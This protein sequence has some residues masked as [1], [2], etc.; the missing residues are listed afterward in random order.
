VEMLSPHT[1]DIRQLE[2]QKYNDHT[3]YHDSSDKPNLTALLDDVTLDYIFLFHFYTVELMLDISMKLE[4][5]IAVNLTA[6]SG[7]LNKVLHL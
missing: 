1:L 7:L 2:E 4:M 3:S 5:R 6:H